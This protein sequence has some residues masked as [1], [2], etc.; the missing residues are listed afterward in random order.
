[1]NF[2]SLLLS[3]EKIITELN[4]NGKTQSASFF[5]S[6]YEE[7]KMKGSHVSREVIKELSTCR[8]MSQYA[9]FSIKEEK[10]LDNVVD[11]AIELKSI[12]P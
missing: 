12:I 6:R 1:M 3:L 2:N 5:I 7:I 9:N 8:A 11:D 10:L 4:K